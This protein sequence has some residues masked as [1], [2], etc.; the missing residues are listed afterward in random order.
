MNHSKKIIV[1]LEENQTISAEDLQDIDHFISNNLNLEIAN[2][3][4]EKPN[5]SLNQL[6]EK[7]QKYAQTQSEQDIQQQQNCQNNL[8]ALQ[9]YSLQIETNKSHLVFLI[10]VSQSMLQYVMDSKSLHVQAVEIILKSILDSLF[11]VF[12]Q[13]QHKKKSLS[14]LNYDEDKIPEDLLSEDEQGVF[15]NTQKTFITIY[16][17][18]QQSKEVELI[19]DHILVCKENLKQIYANVQNAIK[20]NIYQK[21]QKLKDLQS[22]KLS[23]KMSPTSSFKGSEKKS[24]KGESYADTSF[25]NKN[26][27]NLSLLQAMEKVIKNVKQEG[28]SFCLTNLCVITDG[29]SYDDME[30]N[31]FYQN[32][33]SQIKLTGFSCNIICSG[34]ENGKN[35]AF[36]YVVFDDNLRKLAKRLNGKFHRAKV[37]EVSTAK[38]SQIKLKAIF[39]CCNVKSSNQNTFHQKWEEEEFS[40]QFSTDYIDMMDD[41]QME[42][43]E[44][45][46]MEQKNSSSQN[47]QN[48]ESNVIN[49]NNTTTQYFLKKNESQDKQFTP[50]QG[51]FNKKFQSC[52]GIVTNSEE[53]AQKN[54]TQK[55]F[56]FLNE[57]RNM[58]LSW[59]Y[60]RG[61]V[62][63]NNSPRTQEAYQFCDISGLIKS[64]TNQQDMQKIQNDYSILKKIFQSTYNQRKKQYFIHMK[65]YILEQGY[66][67]DIIK[68]RHLEDCYKFMFNNH[69]SIYY[70]ITRIIDPDDYLQNTPH[71]GSN[72]INT[73]NN[74]VQIS[75]QSQT[76]SDYQINI[77]VNSSLSYYSI[78]KQNYEKPSKY[79]TKK[80]LE[81]LKNLIDTIKE[82][83]LNLV[84]SIDKLFY[85]STNPENL[86]QG[87]I[88]DINCY[89]ESS[90]ALQQLNNNPQTWERYFIV[91]DINIVWTPNPIKKSN[92]Q[93]DSD[94]NYFKEFLLRLANKADKN[95][96]P[97]LFLRARNPFSIIEQIHGKQDTL[98]ITEE[99]KIQET[100][101]LYVSQFILLKVIK[102]S[103]YCTQLKIGFRNY[104]KDYRKDFIKQIKQALKN[105]DLRQVDLNIMEK[106]LMPLFKVEYFDTY[107]L[108]LASK[109][110][111]INLQR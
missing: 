23:P 46:K 14:L 50:K 86:P 24:L 52:G 98:N 103:K 101:D 54:K 60:F 106:G 85:Y 67:K 20:E 19:I 18:G 56:F 111:S 89:D 87:V 95:L 68:I 65:K 17:F 77:F 70:T 3:L 44:P 79:E 30:E 75:S 29:V 81:N 74:F 97:T 26:K 45:L 10:D 34:S 15:D 73:N 91:K 41:Y 93:Q 6:K 22:P 21:K 96:S 71:N 53:N 11:N 43:I 92:F 37:E 62:Y 57:I 72:N 38:S 35:A 8:P 102:I 16:L 90:K 5:L 1:N 55:Q 25:L 7:I 47:N 110:H 94:I 61:K 100:D 63:L 66:L 49:N 51:T 76:W 88:F 13:K 27:G 48:N 69:L 36:S 80:D 12:E 32:I 4:Y 104:M 82:M 108:K 33:L 31:E 83:D 59:E 40:K 9:K 58:L 84:F 28:Q 109:T 107:S 99:Q 78:I 39:D 42:E 105:E 2:K 64:S